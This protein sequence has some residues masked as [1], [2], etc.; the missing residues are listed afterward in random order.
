MVKTRQHC[1][2]CNGLN[3]SY[4]TMGAGPPLLLLHGGW[5]TGSLNWANILKNWQNIILL[6][7]LITGPWKNQ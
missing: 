5:E 7:R 6:F 2:S 3:I 1:I 4:L